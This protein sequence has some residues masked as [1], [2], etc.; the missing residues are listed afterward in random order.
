MIALSSAVCMES[1]EE[2]GA[3]EPIEGMGEVE[4]EVGKAQEESSWRRVIAMLGIRDGGGEVEKRW[5]AW[6]V[7]E[8][9]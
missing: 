7:C 5:V 6:G 1:L 3:L 9:R 2:E 8:V 4:R